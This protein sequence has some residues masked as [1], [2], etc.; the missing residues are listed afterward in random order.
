MHE[1]EGRPFEGV[2]LRHMNIKTALVASDNNNNNKGL[3]TILRLETA[4]SDWHI[5]AVESLADWIWTVRCEGRIST[6]HEPVICG[7]TPVVEATLTHRVSGKR[8]YDAFDRVGFYYGK[9]FQQLQS[10]RTDRSVHQATGD[11]TVTE[12]PGVMQGEY[13]YFL[14]PSTIDA[15]LHLIIISIHDGKHKGMPWGVVPARIEEV[16]LFPA[17]QNAGWLDWACCGM[18]Q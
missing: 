5:S 10:V 9:T 18:D 8:W 7:G 12:S 17:G 13:R 4:K 3:E 1:T 15:C 11:V 16:S 6:V 2:T 14:H